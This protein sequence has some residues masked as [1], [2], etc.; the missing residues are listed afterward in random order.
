MP[1]Q[2]NKPSVGPDTE[3]V[4]CELITIIFDQSTPSTWHPSGNDCNSTHRQEVHFSSFFSSGFITVIVVKPPERK[5]AKCTSVQ[6]TKF[7]GCVGSCGYVSLSVKFS[8]IH[9]YEEAT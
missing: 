3:S 4:D 6:C 8:M 2:I 5:L 9:D 7:F 1:I